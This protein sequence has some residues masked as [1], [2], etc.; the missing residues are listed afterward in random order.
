MLDVEPMYPIRHG[1]Y[2]VDVHGEIIGHVDVADEFE[3][4]DERGA[5]WV[6]RK[7]QEHD[8]EILKLEAMKATFI[9]NLDAMIQD[10]RRGKAWLSLKFSG[11]LKAWAQAQLKGKAKTLKTPYGKLS[12]RKV[13]AKVVVTD[14]DRALFWARGYA[15]E[16]IVVKESLS[17]TALKEHM[18]KVT[19][20]SGLQVEPEH[21]RFAV[22]TSVGR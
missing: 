4:R 19:R 7:L 3:V 8:A 5:H 21:E 2:L 18:D 16:A 20:N 22:D 17:L 1:N 14:L 12:F 6:L 9:N 10:Q 13:P 15:P 11:Q